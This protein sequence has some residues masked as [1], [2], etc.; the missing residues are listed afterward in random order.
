MYSSEILLQPD[1]PRAEFQARLRQV[2][3]TDRCVL[4][5]AE[6]G[7]TVHALVAAT[8]AYFHAD[9]DEAIERLAR[10]ELVL[11]AMPGADAAV[12]QDLLGTLVREGSF[13]VR[14]NARF[15]RILQAFKAAGQTQRLDSGFKYSTGEELRRLR[16]K[17]LERAWFENVL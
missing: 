3:T 16:Q 4:A 12:T 5:T 14:S 17:R 1:L 10:M 7:V 9:D 15:I 6:A 11:A 8:L 13:T 2:M